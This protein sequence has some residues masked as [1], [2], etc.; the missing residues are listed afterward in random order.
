[1]VPSPHSAS[2]MGRRTTRFAHSRPPHAH[3]PLYPPLHHLHSHDPPA[4]HPPTTA[5]GAPAARARPRRSTHGTDGGRESESACSGIPTPLTGF[6]TEFMCTPAHASAALRHPASPD[7]PLFG[8]C[9]SQASTVSQSP[10]AN[11]AV[12]SSG[13]AKPAF[14]H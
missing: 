1:M 9:A 2:R 5:Q 14:Y 8:Y 6:G 3:M 13:C 11:Q 7:T 10:S 12:S 4:A